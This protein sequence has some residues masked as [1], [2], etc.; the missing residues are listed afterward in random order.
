MPRT[1]KITQFQLR[2][3]DQKQKK[4]KNYKERK[5]YKVNY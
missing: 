4:M 5:K 3:S 1:K 2:G